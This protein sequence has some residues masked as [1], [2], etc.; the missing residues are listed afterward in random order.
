V[1][2]AP[3]TLSVPFCWSRGVWSPRRAP[4]PLHPRPTAVASTTARVEFGA[5]SFRGAP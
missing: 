2:E 3:N 1:L 5:V 4:L